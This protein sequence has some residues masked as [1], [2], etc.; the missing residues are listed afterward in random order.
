MLIE[1]WVRSIHRNF[2]LGGHWDWF[3]ELGITQGVKFFSM[4]RV[5]NDRLGL[6][7]GPCR[8]GICVPV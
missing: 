2:I 7:V 5:G 1:F 6:G 8:V 3:F 4:D